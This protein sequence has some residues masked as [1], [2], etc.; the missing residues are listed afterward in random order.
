M[1]S[2]NCVFST[3][4]DPKDGQ[5]PAVSQGSDPTNA[6]IGA[7][8]GNSNAIRYGTR[9]RTNSLMWDWNLP[10]GELLSLHRN[11]VSATYL[12]NKY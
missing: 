3:A 4:R 2:G 7:A 12:C 6:F 8:R 10:E 11:T 9:Q 5:K 1:N